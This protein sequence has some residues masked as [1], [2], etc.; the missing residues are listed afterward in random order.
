[1][2]LSWLYDY[3]CRVCVRLAPVSESEF[4]EKLIVESR[5]LRIPSGNCP[6]V[7]PTLSARLGNISWLCLIAPI[8]C[9]LE[10]SGVLQFVWKSNVLVVWSVNLLLFVVIGLLNILYPIRDY[11]FL[12]DSTLSNGFSGELTCGGSVT[13]SSV[14]SLLFLRT[15]LF[16]WLMSLMTS[17]SCFH[18]R[19]DSVSDCGSSLTSLSSN[20]Q[21][22]SG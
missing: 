5:L 21:W 20:S 11:F 7:A 12:D 19:V 6:P 3:L 17:I 1:M 15:T 14:S 10:S 13:A 4:E 9:R 18:F 16:T 8:S 2:N 22:L